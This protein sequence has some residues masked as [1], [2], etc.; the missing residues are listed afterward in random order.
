MMS[1]ERAIHAEIGNYTMREESQGRT[2]TSFRVKKVNEDLKPMQKDD[3]D[4]LYQRHLL[5]A[6]DRAKELATEAER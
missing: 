1:P 5:S 6:L 2:P 3:T 4:S